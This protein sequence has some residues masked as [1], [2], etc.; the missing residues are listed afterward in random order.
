MGVGSCEDRCEAALPF[1]GKLGAPLREDTVHLA[2]DF[3]KADG[4][5]W[6]GEGGSGSKTRC[7]AKSHGAR[8]RRRRSSSI[9]SRRNLNILALV[10]VFVLAL[11]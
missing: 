7:L 3:A 1:G 4:P 9:S 8:R 2:T 6:E 10:Q 5:R 11:G